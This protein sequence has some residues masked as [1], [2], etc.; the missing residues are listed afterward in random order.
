MSVS[1]QKLCSEDAENPYA[2]PS[3]DVGIPLVTGESEMEAV[4]RQF[5]HLESFAQA[6]G[7]VC[8]ICAIYDGIVAVYWAGWVILVKLGAM[9]TPWPIHR[10]SAIFAI[11]LAAL[12]AITGLAAG[13]GLRR[14]RS[15]SSWTL[16]AF[17]LAPFL[18]FVV[19]AHDEHQ[20]GNLKDALMML[21]LGAMLLMPGAALWS[22][23]PGAILSKDYGRVVSK[24][25][26]IRVRAKLPLAVKYIMALLLFILISLAWSL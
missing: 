2:S 4:R 5:A 11:A 22:L 7:I 13:Y 24:T 1:W 12:V 18:Q 21:V 14:V 8:I 23:D 15:W 10:S 6:V 26:H 17:S 16:G 25:P 9:S 19:G 3:D 20:R